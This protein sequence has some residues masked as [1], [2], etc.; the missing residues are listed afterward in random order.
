MACK[1][2]YLNDNKYTVNKRDHKQKQASADG[3]NEMISND[4]AATDITHSSPVS[5]EWVTQNS[6]SASNM[7]WQNKTGILKGDSAIHFA[8]RGI[9]STTSNLLV[10]AGPD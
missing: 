3:G 2:K 1:D 8:F 4:S 6:L 5:C 9:A 7:N 10:R